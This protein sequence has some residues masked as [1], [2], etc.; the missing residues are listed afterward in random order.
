MN[1]E[2]C[3]RGETGFFRTALYSTHVSLGARMMEFHGW[4][5]PVEYSGI[6]EEHK[7]VRGYAGLFDVSHMNKLKVKGAKALD[8]L[9]NISTNDISKLRLNGMK[10]SVVCRDDGTIVDDIV[11]IRREDHYFLVTNT[12]RKEILM[13]WLEDHMPDG[14]EIEDVTC[15]TAALALQGPG[16]NDILSAI[17]ENLDEIRSWSGANR[18][19][20]DIH[21]Y[22]TRS[23]YTGEDGFEIYSRSEDAAHLWQSIMETG[24]KNIKPA[25]LGA[26]DTL[27]LEM[28]YI[29]SGMDIS[30]DNNPLE[31]G[32]EWA[33]K[34]RKDFTG[35][36][37]LR[38]IKEQGVEKK[39]TGIKLERGIPRHGYDIVGSSGE[40]I[41]VVTSGT[42]SPMLG[43]GIGLGYVKPEYALPDTK[44]GIV[45]RNKTYNGIVVKLPFLE[46]RK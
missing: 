37:A 6:I 23:G 31:A 8:F 28:G 39:L 36:D 24:G 7:A 29:L 10:Y 12:S 32:L 15:D 35:K 16:S 38:R 30:D 21:T 14:V 40:K 26:R 25:G 44:I 2:T 9:Q 45:I 1:S 4:E 20:A 3:D 13:K 34:W 33:V 42:N 41:G 17:S 18:K 43:A 46:G 19:V 5:M 22:I 27:R 11:I